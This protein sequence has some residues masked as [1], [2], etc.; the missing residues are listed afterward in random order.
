LQ[1]LETFFGG[2][3]SDFF[4]LFM[5]PGGGHCGAAYNY[6]ASPGT[7]H[8]VEALVSWVERGEKPGSL[9]STGT[10]GGAD[11]SRLL[12]PWPQTATYIGGNINVSSS[13]VC[14]I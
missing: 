7:Y 9:L 10:D 6:P 2:D 11:I 12:C 13:Y 5:V 1:D 4:N 8:V 3:I 14:E